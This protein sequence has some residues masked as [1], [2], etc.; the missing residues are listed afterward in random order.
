MEDFQ[1]KE[2]HRYNPSFRDVA[3]TWSGLARTEVPASTAPGELVEGKVLDYS[4]ADIDSAFEDTYVRQDRPVLLANFTENLALASKWTDDYFGSLTPQPLIE[5]GSVSGQRTYSSDSKLRIPIREY[6]NCRDRFRDH[7]MVGWR[8]EDD[9]S[10]LNR[11]YTLPTFHPKDIIELL[12]RKFRFNRRWIFM[13]IGGQCS[14]LH[15]DCFRSAAWIMMVRGEKILRMVS[16]IHEHLIEAGE[17]LF[18]ESVL[19]RLISCGVDVIQFHLYPG[20]IMYLPASWLH[21]IKNIQDN[22]MVTGCFA[23]PHQATTVLPQIR[24]LVFKDAEPMDN[25]MQRLLTVLKAD[26]LSPEARYLLEKELRR[27]EAQVDSL[28]HSRELLRRLVDGQGSLAAV[29]Q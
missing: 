27:I 14:D 12:P 24:D 19:Q 3:V 25:S 22:L 10:H 23:A 7:Y 8:Y 26:R 9:S 4:S 28:A 2:F 21:Q 5:L 6:V 16:P 11:D 17:S 29:D 18:D 13:G 20:T 1:S 15:Y